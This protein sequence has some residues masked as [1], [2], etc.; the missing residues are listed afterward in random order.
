MDLRLDLSPRDIQPLIDALEQLEDAPPANA[1]YRSVALSAGFKLKISVDYWDR[2]V[3]HLRIRHPLRHHRLVVK[4]CRVPDDCG[5]TYPPTAGGTIS[6]A[7]RGNQTMQEQVDT[8]L[9]EWAHALVFDLGGDNAHGDKWGK[10]HAAIYRTW[11]R[12]NG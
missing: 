2:L 12:W 9:H 1:A 11:E 6:I 8:L 4:R 5:T 10:K 3:R 7:V